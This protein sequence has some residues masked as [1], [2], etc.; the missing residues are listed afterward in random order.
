[1]TFE[2]ELCVYTTDNSANFRRHLNSS[3]H[4]KKCSDKNTCHKCLKSFLN[5]AGFTKHDKTCEAELVPRAR[6][7][8]YKQIL[9]QAPIDTQ[10]NI[11]NLNVTLQNPNEV[12]LIKDL[13]ADLSTSRLEQEILKRLNPKHDSFNKIPE[14]NK[15][16]LKH[17]LNK[18]TNNL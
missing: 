2:C 15:R 1:M 8:I 9:N 10:I 6:E 16:S 14:L 7:I 5:K 3:A 17:Y 12:M 4:V 18:S 13:I 11:E